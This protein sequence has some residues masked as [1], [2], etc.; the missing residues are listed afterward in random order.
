MRSQRLLD[1]RS[2][3]SGAVAKNRDLSGQLPTERLCMNSF[4]RAAGRR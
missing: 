3:E 1:V 2:S 4:A